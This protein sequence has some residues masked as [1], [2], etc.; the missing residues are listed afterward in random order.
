MPPHDPRELPPATGVGWAIFAI[1]TPR[2]QE[3]FSHEEVANIVDAEMERAMATGSRIDPVPMPP[4][5]L[6]VVCAAPVNQEQRLVICYIG[7]PFSPQAIVP[8]ALILDVATENHLYMWV[9][10]PENQ[11]G[12]HIIAAL[13]LK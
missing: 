5:R 12:L 11:L 7:Q 8:W 6:V 1:C 13:V 3:P 10:A 2:T 4:E 9:A